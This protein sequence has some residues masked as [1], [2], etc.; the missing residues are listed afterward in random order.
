VHTIF[1]VEFG[2]H[3][4]ADSIASMVTGLNSHGL[5]S[6]D[7]DS[8]RYSVDVHRPAR[9]AALKKQLQS[10]ESYGFLT[11]QANKSTED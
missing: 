10:W 4:P 9:A 6:R 11:W 3:V 1:H 5:L 8:R 7:G 2:V